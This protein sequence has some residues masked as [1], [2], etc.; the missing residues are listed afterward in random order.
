MFPF[1]PGRT[2]RF[3]FLRQGRRG[4]PLQN[5]IAPFVDPDIGNIK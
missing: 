4:K 2:M 1:A 5:E 3:I